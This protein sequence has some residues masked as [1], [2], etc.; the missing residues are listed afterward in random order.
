M[1]VLHKL[2]TTNPSLDLFVQLKM[3][4][5]GIIVDALKHKFSQPTHVEWIYYASLYYGVQALTSSVP[6]N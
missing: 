5:N 4:G 6:A 3:F 1:L 2:S